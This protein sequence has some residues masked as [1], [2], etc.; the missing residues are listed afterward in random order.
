[1]SVLIA[2]LGLWMGKSITSLLQC[3]AYCGKTACLLDCNYTQPVS[4]LPLF[5]R[6]LYCQLR[7]L[8]ESESPLYLPPGIYG[9][10]FDPP[11]PFPSSTA[12]ALSVSFH[13]RGATPPSSLHGPMMDPL[14]YVD[15]SLVLWEHWAQ[16]S[17]YHLTSAEQKGRIAALYVLAPL[18]SLTTKCSQTVY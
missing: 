15:V 11:E 16:H 3:A 2:R 6:S 14:L 12:W 1:M 10:G 5:W 9:R 8:Y 13:R 17:K 7:C 4:S 18:G